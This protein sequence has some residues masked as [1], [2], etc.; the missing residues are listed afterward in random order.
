MVERKLYNLEK[1]TEFRRELHKNPELAFEEVVT[2]AKIIEYLK[3]LGV[4]DSQIRR[5]A[6]TGITVDIKGKAPPVLQQDD[7][8]NNSFFT[9]LERKTVYDSFSRRY[10]LLANESNVL[11]HQILDLSL[12]L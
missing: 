3:G 11:L 5:I 8:E 7:I 12:H 1:L 9:S 4:V 10:G 6:K 2:S